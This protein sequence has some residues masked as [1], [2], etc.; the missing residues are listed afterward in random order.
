MLSYQHAFHAANHADLF[1]HACL[2]ALLDKLTK[3]PK[4]FFYL[5]THSGNGLY[6][7]GLKK[8]DEVEVTKYLNLQSSI[9]SFEKYINIIKPFLAKNSYPGSPL[10]VTE[11]LQQKINELDEEARQ[12]LNNK[13]KSNQ[14]HLNELHPNVFP[15][16]KHNTWYP[17]THLHNRDG[18]ELL[19]ALMP[20]KPNR[21]IVFIDPPYENINE[22]EQVENA[23]L[24]AIQKW[25]QGIIVIWY[26][27]LSPERI[28]HTSRQIES[29]PKHGF[30]ENMVTNLLNKL[31]I[32]L[33]DCRFARYEPSEKIGMYGSGMLII[34]PPY[35]V[36][37]ECESI[38]EFLLQNTQESD[39]NLSEIN[40]LKQ[41][42]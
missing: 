31:D 26:P 15:E 16:L 4:P 22:Y 29:N 21:G 9:P 14:I 20:P 5:D 28:A 1:K 39:S 37:K 33:L 18:F 27:L 8:Q 41:P 13:Y 40:M 36:E 25:P 24:K 32:G 34:N 35:Q 7:L 23:A 2:C 42:Y 6:E 10:V 38:L 19:N 11:Y 17:N 12:I 30:S 3:K